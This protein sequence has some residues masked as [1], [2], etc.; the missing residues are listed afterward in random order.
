MRK[1]WIDCVLATV[2]VFLSI[3][4]LFRITQLQVFNAFDPIGQALGDV[5]LTDYVF[6]TL[7]KD[8]DVDE[9][10]VIVNIGNLSRREIAEQ[11]QRI[12]KYGPKVIGIDGFF[13]CSKGLRDTVNCPQLRDTFGN[14]MLSNAIEEAGNVILVT[15]VLQSDTLLPADVYDSLRRSDSLFTVPAIREGYANL[16]TDAAF[17]DDVK[18]CRLFN[19]KLDIKGKP[20][21]AFAVEMAMEYDSIKTQKFLQRNNYSEVINYRGNVYDIFGSTNYP[22]MFYTLDIEDIAT[23]NFV[24]EMI[25][26]KIVIFG[27]LGE[28]LGDPS[29]DD[30]F[31]TPL[32]KKLAGKANPDMFGAVVHA[33]IVSM[34]LNEDYVNQMAEWQEVAMAILLCLLNVALFSLINIKLPLWYDGI[35]KLLQLIQLLL[36]SVL[37][38]MIFAWYSFK[39]NVT[40]TLAAVALV[41][42]VYEVYMSVFKNIYYK[43]KGWF[44][45]TPKEESVLTSVNSEES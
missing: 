30:K 13:D 24:P 25:K 37:M 29:W 2:L 12:S 36:Y 7:R 17:Q 44:T 5:E 1:F 14:L 21:Y 43:I 10:I 28:Y 34:I 40:L 31:Y 27:F 39:F 8:P 6:S 18:T 16:D 41:G 42:D 32:N 22:Q 19:P 4:G 38:V 9:N 11:I 33:N 35:T 15:K 20:H 23:E 3:W 45:I 26:G